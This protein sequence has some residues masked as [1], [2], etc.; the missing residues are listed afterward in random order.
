MHEKYITFYYMKKYILIVLFVILCSYIGGKVFIYTLKNDTDNSVEQFSNSEIST[1]KEEQNICLRNTLNEIRQKRKQEKIDESLN[2]TCSFEMNTNYLNL[3]NPTQFD[4]D[5]FCCLN[6]DKCKP[7]TEV[8]CTYGPTNYP[9]PQILSEFDKLN[10]M[11]SK[12]HYFTLQDYINWLKCFENNK[13]SLN[14]KHLKNL[15]KVLKGEKPI[16]NK[17]I[18]HSEFIPP[19][20][21]EDYFNDKIMSYETE[22]VKNNV[23]TI[24][25]NYDSYP[26]F[27]KNFQTLGLIGQQN[28][29][30]GKYNANLVN[31][32]TRPKI[33]N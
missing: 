2:G 14:Y 28:N 15:E 4:D 7:N 11:Q 25:Y 20:T 29:T 19:I 24:P 5:K 9:D 23:P 30:S 32:F 18:K 16:F 31:N 8:I 33:S 1:P 26:N 3:L 12:V 13:S 6:H 17:D 10:F 27:S 22:I 21:S